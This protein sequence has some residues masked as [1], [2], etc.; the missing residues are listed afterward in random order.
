MK[1]LQEDIYAM[2]DEHSNGADRMFP[3]YPT[4]TFNGVEVPTFVMR[5]KN[6]SINSQLLTNMMS[7]MDDHSLFDRSD[8]VNPFLIYDGHGS[9]FEEVF[10][11]YTVESNRHWTCFIGVSYGTSVWYLGDSPEQNGTCKIESKKAKEE[12]IWRNIHAGLPAII[13]RTDIVRIMDIAWQKSFARV[14]TNLKVIAERGWGGL[15]YV[16]LDHP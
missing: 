2:K 4:C 5:S 12:T 15:M 1:S 14:D 8:G 7:K 10:L 13:E 16:L 11:E 9:R 3:L 6:G